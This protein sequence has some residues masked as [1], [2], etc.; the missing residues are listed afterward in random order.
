MSD[1]ATNGLTFGGYFY[2]HFL[3]TRIFKKSE[4]RG[5][6][7]SKKTGLP[8]LIDFFNDSFNENR[9]YFNRIKAGVIIRA[10]Y[11]QAKYYPIASAQE[12]V[13][14]NKFARL[15][16]ESYLANGKKLF[17]GKNKFNSINEVMY[18]FISDLYDFWDTNQIVN[19]TGNEVT[20][21]FN[22]KTLLDS[23]IIS[24]RNRKISSINAAEN[25]ADEEQIIKALDLAAEKLFRQCD[26][27]PQQI[28]NQKK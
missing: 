2:D 24:Y 17:P 18:K 20:R 21:K 8:K 12:A 10:I 28:L 3:S 16:F 13:S 4:V 15:E 1:I 9:S 26:F 19:S 11:W 6:F 25:L 5:T 22:I 14:K 27:F 7:L 23:A